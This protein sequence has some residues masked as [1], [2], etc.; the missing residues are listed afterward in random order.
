M[1]LLEEKKLLY[2]L[3]FFCLSGT[4]GYADEGNYFSSKVDYFAEGTTCP[5]CKEQAAVSEKVNQDLGAM[6]AGI[7]AAKGG[8]SEIMLFLDPG[9]QFFDGAVKNLNKFSQQHPELAVKVF[10]NG[11]LK[12]FLVIGK[13]LG[14]EHPQWVITNDLTGGNAHDFGVTKVPAYVLSSKGK[15]YRVYGTPDLN[16]LMERV[17]EIK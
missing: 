12:D 15:F 2:L 3:I 4:L 10:I 17:N 8:P 9:C 7:I 6:R 13:P 1:G 16:N 14:Q 5:T 11:P